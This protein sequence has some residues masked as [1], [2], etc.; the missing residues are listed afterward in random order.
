MDMK[1][2]KIKQTKMTDEELVDRFITLHPVNIADNGFTKATLAQIPQDRGRLVARLWTG[3]CWAIGIIWLIMGINTDQIWGLLHAFAHSLLKQLFTT[4]LASNPLFLLWAG[5][6]TIAF[7]LAYN[8][9]LTEEE[10]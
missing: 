5:G 4:S 1:E 8:I 2:N 10:P 9:V 6:V 3:L 7:V